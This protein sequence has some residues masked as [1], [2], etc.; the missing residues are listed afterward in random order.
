MLREDVQNRLD[1]LIQ[2]TGELGLLREVAAT[3]AAGQG[4]VIP[5]LHHCWS[6]Q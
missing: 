1:S 5:E 2:L 4:C 6:E 3:A